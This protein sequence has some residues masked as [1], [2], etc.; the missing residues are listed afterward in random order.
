MAADDPSGA[1]AQ[2]D[3]FPRGVSAK[4]VNAGPTNNST[5]QQGGGL[6]ATCESQRQSQPCLQDGSAVPL[7]GFTP[8]GEPSGHYAQVLHPLACV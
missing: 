6:A 8:E 2:S 1:A 5:E 7:C 3:I 4:S